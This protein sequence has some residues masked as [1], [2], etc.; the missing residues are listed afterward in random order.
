MNIFLPE[1]FV[2]KK[3]VFGVKL[4]ESWPGKSTSI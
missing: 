4:T 2:A 3:H 1:L